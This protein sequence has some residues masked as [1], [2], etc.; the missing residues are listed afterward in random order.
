[1]PRDVEIL[2]PPP[3]LS[4]RPLADIGGAGDAGVLALLGL[5]TMI[6][7]VLVVVWALM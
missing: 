6:D 7:A 4:A 3:A 5:F 1:M 2:V